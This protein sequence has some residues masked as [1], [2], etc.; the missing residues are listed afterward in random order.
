MWS[1][2]TMLFDASVRT[3]ALVFELGARQGLVERA[4]GPAFMPRPAATLGTSWGRLMLEPVGSDEGRSGATLGDIASFTVDF[5][6]QY[7]GLVGAVSDDGAGPPLVTSGLID[8]G[9]C[10]WGER[11][12]RFAKRRYEAPRVDLVALSPRLQRWAA[13]RLVPKILVANQTRGIEAVL[14]PDGAWLPSVP[15]LTCTSNRLDDAYAVLSSRVASQWVLERAAGS[16]LSPD[17]VR[18]TPS[19]LASIPL[20]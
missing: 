11:P 2:P 13:A 20:P 14:D 1:S 5:R 15:V 9:R 19:L 16:G 8:P 18:L 7:Y 4:W 10:W 17:S 6:D 3:C 12:V